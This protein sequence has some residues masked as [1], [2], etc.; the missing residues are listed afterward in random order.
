[1]LGGEGSTSNTSLCPLFGSLWLFVGIAF[2]KC[3]AETGMAD[4]MTSNNSNTQHFAFPQCFPSVDFKCLQRIGNV[5][6]LI[7][8]V[9]EL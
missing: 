6:G 3:T 8:Q 1:M 4:V 5:S 2:L 7:V 9:K